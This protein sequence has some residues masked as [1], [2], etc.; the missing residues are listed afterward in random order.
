[1]TASPTVD[2]W[3]PFGTVSKLRL[4]IP[5]AECGNYAVSPLR[6]LRFIGYAICGCEGYL[7]VSLCGIQ[8]SDYTADIEA[9]QY[10][11][12]SKGKLDCNAMKA[13]LTLLIFSGLPRLVD[14]DAMDE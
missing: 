1:M 11:F 6:G 9:R 5:L 8:V 3:L 7:S 4:S 10:Y 12:I 13:L 14:T 2:L